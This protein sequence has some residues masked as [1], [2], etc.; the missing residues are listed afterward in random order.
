MRK[1][2]TLSAETEERLAELKAIFF[3]E[4]GARVTEGWLVNV[5]IKKLY[6]E[7]KKEKKNEQ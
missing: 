3:E 1:T 6:D 7:K 5:A 2:L 4:F